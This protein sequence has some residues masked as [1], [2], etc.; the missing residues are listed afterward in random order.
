MKTT[1]D[2]V[3]AKSS[4]AQ[5][6]SFHMSESKITKTEMAKRM[7]TT[8]SQ[9]DRLLDPL[10]PSATLQTLEKAAQALGKSLSITFTDRANAN[11]AGQH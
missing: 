9:L 8:R 6:I 2:I 10:N 4:L 1:T 7:G 3:Q 11:E 5:Q